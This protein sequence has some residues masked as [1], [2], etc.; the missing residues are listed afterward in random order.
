MFRAKAKTNQDERSR[1]KKIS[2]N[3]L[4]SPKPE[5]CLSISVKLYG[6]MPVNEPRS[7]AACETALSLLKA[8]LIAPK[9]RK[10]RATIELLPD[11]FIIKRTNA[12]SS[13]FAYQ[14]MAYIWSDPADS[15]TCGLVFRRALDEDYWYEFHGYKLERGPSRL[16]GALK[17][18]FLNFPTENL[19]DMKDEKLG[20]ENKE[21]E[22]E[23][24]DTDGAAAAAPRSNSESFVKNLLDMEEKL[25]A[26]GAENSSSGSFSSSFSRTP[27]A[28]I[29][30][31]SS[32]VGSTL[33][34]L[35]WTK[36]DDPFD[37]IATAARQ[38][39]EQPVW[40]NTNINP[41]TVGQ[42]LQQQPTGIPTIS[43]MVYPT[44]GIAIDQWACQPAIPFKNAVQ[45]TRTTLNL[46]GQCKAI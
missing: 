6:L 33:G 3:K 35:S 46:S 20:G 22:N 39:N 21:M 15:R 42:E 31:P 25:D 34:Q 1:K 40:Q 45:W 5:V 29:D 23:E 11:K 12:M 16:I 43:G 32:E 36:F 41:F 10:P 18:M 19:S 2:T 26:P 14:D 17:Y 8:K 24:H 27:W 37:E 4:S 28:S 30:E 7:D 9:T 38:I 44:T 13:I